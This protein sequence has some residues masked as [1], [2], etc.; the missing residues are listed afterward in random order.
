MTSSLFLTADW[1]FIL[2]NDF[3]DF[4]DCLIGQSGKIQSTK[5]AQSSKVNG[6]KEAPQVFTMRGHINKSINCSFC[7]YSLLI[8][9]VLALAFNTTLYVPPVVMV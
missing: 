1:P 9:K 7:A 5:S 2:R 8:V 3:Y 4:V 6:Q